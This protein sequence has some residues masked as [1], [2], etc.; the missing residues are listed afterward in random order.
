MLEDLLRRYACA[1][2]DA[3]ELVPATSRRKPQ[4]WAWQ[5]VGDGLDREW[6]CP[7]HTAAALGREAEYE[8]WLAR[9]AMASHEWLRAN[10]PPQRSKDNADK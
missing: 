9:R 2:C 8:D 4:G 3:V 6:L 7:Q 1:D 5:F 10:P